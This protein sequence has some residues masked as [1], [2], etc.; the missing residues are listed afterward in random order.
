M[1]SVNLSNPSIDAYSYLQFGLQIF[2]SGQDSFNRTAI[3]TI[4]FLLNRQP[5]QLQYYGPFYFIDES[6]C[7]FSGKYAFGRIIVKTFGCLMYLIWI[8]YL[9]LLL[10]KKIKLSAS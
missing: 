1:D 10:R 3:S 5:F 7:C 2:P 8:F 4:G 6:Y 9:Y